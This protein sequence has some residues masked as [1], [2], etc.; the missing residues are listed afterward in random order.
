[1]HASIMRLC[2][3]MAR[4]KGVLIHNGEL[5]PTVLPSS[6]ANP[7]DDSAL[8]CLRALVTS[9]LCFYDTDACTAMLVESIPS[10]M[11]QTSDSGEIEI[12]APTTGII[13]QYVESVA[14][15]EDYSLLRD[16][17]LSSVK[18]R[19]SALT[20]TSEQNIQACEPVHSSDMCLIIGAFEWALL[21]P[22]RRPCMHYPTRSLRVWS[23]ASAMQFLGFQ[24]AAL[25]QVVSMQ[26]DFDLFSNKPPGAQN[27]ATV[28]LVTAQCGKL[29]SWGASLLN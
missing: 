22:A 16:R 5:L 28:F 13:R 10:T 2:P 6:S 27:L 17:V 7:S 15:E 23:V 12:D 19:R 29:I 11:I 1:M 4:C 24:L 21:E 14:A 25:T 8:S 18:G 20:G 3:L 26:E 9:L